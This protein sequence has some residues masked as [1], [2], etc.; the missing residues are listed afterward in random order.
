[1][2]NARDPRSAD[3]DPSQSPGLEGGGGVAPGDVPPIE[4]STAA[5][6][7]HDEGRGGS[8]IPNRVWLVLL[9]LL[10]LGFTV[11]WAVGAILGAAD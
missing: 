7:G 10:V 8:G 2:T 5:A 9:V 4:S 1:M 11:A 6:Q 3:P